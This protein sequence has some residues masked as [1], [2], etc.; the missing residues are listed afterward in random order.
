M[1]KIFYLSFFCFCF[2]LDV[3]SQWT[4]QNSG[5]TYNLKSIYFSAPDTGYVCDENYYVRRT[6]DGGVTWNAYTLLQANGFHFTS[7]NTGFAFGLDLWKTIDGGT[8]WNDVFN[9]QVSYLSSVDFA[10]AD[11]GYASGLNFNMDSLYVFKTIDSGNTWLKVFGISCPAYPS[12]DFMNGNTGLLAVLNII[13][14]TSDG[15]ASWP[16]QYNDSV[17][18]YPIYDI[19]SPVLNTGYAVGC[20]GIILKSVNGGITWSQL[21]NSNTNNLNSVFFTDANNGWAVGGN[22][23]APGP[24]LNT[25]DGGNTWILSTNASVT[26][27]SVYF[28]SPNIGYVC[29][30]NG[31]IMKYNGGAGIFEQQNNLTLN[32]YPN[33]TA[34]K[35]SIKQQGEV[36]IYNSLGQVVYQSTNSPIHHLTIDLSSQSKGIYFIKIQSGE[37]FFTEKLVVQ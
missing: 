16:I 4:N 27:N 6:T 3:F 7:K 37:N 11:T 17:N 22:G 31:T 13:A 29:G 1:K 12:I 34:G 23:M 24:I 25:I 2:S 36:F 18:F 14:R 28:P 20:C 10:N 35:F 8:S 5:T 9:H 32:A 30:E 15:G 26:L 19:H 33:P 21:S